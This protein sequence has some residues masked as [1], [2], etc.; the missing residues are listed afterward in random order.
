MIEDFAEHAAKRNQDIQL[1][2][3]RE[4]STY[5]ALEPAIGL[6]KAV[7]LRNE[8]AETLGDLEDLHWTNVDRIPGFGPE[9]LNKIDEVLSS[10]GLK[11]LDR[12]KIDIGPDILANMLEF[13][14]KDEALEVYKREFK[15]DPSSSKSDDEPKP[16]LS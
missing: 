13:M 10:H 12:N 11:P 3:A 9:T 6:K 2:K 16:P 7:Y 14:P 1:E 15:I 4:L 5:K 8:V